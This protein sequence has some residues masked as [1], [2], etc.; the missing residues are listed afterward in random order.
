VR[1]IASLDV[2]LSDLAEIGGV[3]VAV[4]TALLAPLWWSERRTRSRLAELRAEL[5]DLVARS[6]RL[7]RIDAVVGH[8][9]ASGLLAITGALEAQAGLL[10]RTMLGRCHEIDVDAAMHQ[11]RTARDWV[12][13]S[14]AECAVI[15]GERMSQI[16]ALQQLTHRLGDAQTMS[17]FQGAAKIGSVG[18]LGEDDFIGS[19]RELSSRL[20]MGP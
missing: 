3:V 9:R 2:T 10:H 15:Y 7:E 17:F 6:A 5:D 12:E 16:A 11:L 20:E 14:A 18:A 1:A 19:A 4:V 8:S 13:R